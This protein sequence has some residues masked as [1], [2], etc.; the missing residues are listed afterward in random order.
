[1]YFK[2]S[3]DISSIAISGIHV[4]VFSTITHQIF[5]A[6][7]NRAAKSMAT[8]PPIKQYT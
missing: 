1:M 8:A 2:S 3:E 7:S 5:W 4:N 6:Y